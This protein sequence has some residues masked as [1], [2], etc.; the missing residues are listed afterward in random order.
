MRLKRTKVL[1]TCLVVLVVASCSRSPEAREARYLEKGKKE[2][3][4]KNYPVAILHFKNAV[5]A[6]PLDA[7]PYYQLGISYLAL[8]DIQTGGTYL[9][10]ATELN[11]KHTAA[12]LRFAELLD[13]GDKE[14]VEDAQQRA[15]KVLTLLPDDVGALDVLAVAELRLGT[16]ESAEAHLQQAL[17]KSPGHLPSS[18]ALAQLRL[19]P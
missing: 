7:E 11:P 15:L 13:A 1:L 12:Q 2:F 18:I 10:R 14:N 16:P 3:Q 5:T 4:K 8:N 9:R 19:A 17:R 6:Q